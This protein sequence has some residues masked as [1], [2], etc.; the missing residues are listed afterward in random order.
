MAGLD[1]KVQPGLFF[2]GGFDLQM[3]GVLLRIGA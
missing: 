2:M 3:P 1:R